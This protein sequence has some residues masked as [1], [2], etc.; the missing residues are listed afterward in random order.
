MIGR[1]LGIDPGEKRIGL[2]VSDAMGVAARE[3]QIRPRRG[4]AEDFAAIRYI[5]EEHAIAGIVVGVP[6]NPNAPEGI[7]T[8]ADAVRE[9]ISEMRRAIPLPIAEVSEY[10]TSQEARRLAQARKRHPREPVDDLAARIILQSF[11]DALSYGNATF[12]PSAT[13]E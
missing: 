13:H 11:L 2:A 3:L 8:Q 1:L 5:A 10:L 7:R 6:I 12:P 9:W 4:N